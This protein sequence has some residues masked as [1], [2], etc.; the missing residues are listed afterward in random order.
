MPEI[1]LKVE[2]EGFKKNRYDLRSTEKILTSYRQIID[3][4]IPLII[5]QKT[6]TERLR[7]DIRYETEFKHGS[8]EV[9][10][11]IVLPSAGIF[12]TVIGNDGG[13]FI[14]QKVSRLINV[15][16]DFRRIYT[17]FLEKGEKPKLGLE[18][19]NQP[20]ITVNV[21]NI[22]SGEGD[23]K[24]TPI[25]LPAAINTKASIDRLI[26]VVDGY[27]VDNVIVKSDEA[28]SQ[29]TNED[30]RIIGT[31]KEELPNFI[32]L[33]G[34]LDSAAFTAHRGSLVTDSG[35]FPITWDEEIRDK[36]RTLVDREGMLFRA[37]PII[38]HRRFKD[39][40]VAFHIINCWDPQSR[41]F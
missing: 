4:V 30:Q 2:G 28:E 23:I 15:V 38:D 14:A 7:S 34:R 37:R 27:I 25:V 18:I 31:Q 26:G 20:H 16:V 11:D 40:P 3:G 10:L 32:E 12:A 13:Y 9:W 33:M 36:I 8:L 39:D 24:I 5:G 21:N 22:N 35:R 41:L 19:Q 6:L 1:L 17:D 29:I